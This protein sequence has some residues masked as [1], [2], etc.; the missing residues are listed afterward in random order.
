MKRIALCLLAL[1][2]FGLPLAVASGQASLWSTPRTFE[3][4]GWFPGI[5]VDTTGRV[6]LFWSQSRYYG[7]NPATPEARPSSGYDVVFHT[8]SLDGQTWTPV[9]DVLAIQQYNPGSVE[10]TRPNPWVSPDNILH[11]TFRNLDIFYT[12][13][14]AWEAETAT[15]WRGPVKLNIRNL[16]YF[17]DVIQ[18]SS[19]R[20]HAVYTEN[21]PDDTCPLCYHLFY[22]RS[23]DGGQTWSRPFDLSALEETPLGA[24]KP[25]LLL[26]EQEN[27]H[28]VWEA[29]TGGTLGGVLDPVHIAHAVSF[30]GGDTWPIAHDLSAPTGDTARNVVLAQDAN[31]RLLVAWLDTET[32]QPVFRLSATHGRT[33]EPPQTIPGVYGERHL[34]NTRQSNFALESDSLRRLHLVMVGSL[35]EQMDT[36]AVLYLPWDG[37][38]WGAPEVVAAYPDGSVPEWPQAAIGLGNQLHV[39]WFVRPP[40]HVWDANPDFY[41][42]WYSRRLLSAPS[43]E[44]TPYPTLTP[45][46]TLTPKP[47]PTPT[48]TPLSVP[49]LQPIAPEYTRV[50]YGENDD[51]RIILLSL[52][53][54]TGL[55]G[56]WAAITYRKHRS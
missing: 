15:A 39:T 29:G 22:R 49:D 10:V 9:R 36:L 13:V 16:G 12:Q 41:T 35:P 32:D 47:A 44:A 20:L 42:I 40:E 24:A 34:H 52:L 50:I 53:P 7:A 11:L 43:S 6:H 19:G 37:R 45:T 30:D 31:N 23:D 3:Q 17:S 25:Q 51:L 27:L 18:D 56:L 4:S 38:A 46:P 8:S 48:P 54:V 14:N 1:L 21:Q 28:V 2:L 55:L 33:W 26:D 5:A